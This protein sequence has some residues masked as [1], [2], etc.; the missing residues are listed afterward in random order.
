MPNNSGNARPRA[1]SGALA[2]EAARAEYSARR[3]VAT[4]MLRAASLRSSAWWSSGLRRAKKDSLLAQADLIVGRL[5]RAAHADEALVLTVA[6]DALLTAGIDLGD[7]ESFDVVAGYEAKL[8]AQRPHSG[9][10]L[11]MAIDEIDEGT[12]PEDILTR[13]VET[14]AQ[15]AEA[16][17]MVRWWDRRHPRSSPPRAQLRREFLHGAVDVLA[18]WLDSKVIEETEDQLIDALTA[19]EGSY[20]EKL[21]GGEYPG[22]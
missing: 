7:I 3:E 9:T 19:P 18:A 15:V 16:S 1:R 11:V 22:F 14:P 21:D 17:P 6:Q 2:R 4:E 13:G 10:L 20:P 5:T 8:N 12:F